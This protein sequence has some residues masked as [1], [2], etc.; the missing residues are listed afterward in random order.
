M[1]RS[2]ITWL[3]AALVAGVVISFVIPLCLL[4]RTMAEERAVSATN[5][6]AQSVAMIVAGVDDPASLPAVL[7]PTLGARTATTTVALPS[8]QLIGGPTTTGPVTTGQPSSG[9]AQFPEDAR[10]LAAVRADNRSMATTVDD[11]FHVL[12]PVGVADGVAIVHSVT[13]LGRV[14]RGVYGS[15][16]ILVA[17]GLLLVVVSVLV[18]RRQSA[19]ISTPVVAMA[20]VAHRL[21]SGDFEARAA[22]TGPVEVVELGHALNQLADRI[23][24]L[25]RIER[26]GA[27]D[28]SHRLRTPVTALRL[29]T[30]Q[31]EDPTVRAR[32]RSHVE[33]L[34]RAIDSVVA[35][36]R[37]PSRDAMG[38][39]C[40]ARVVLADRAHHWGPLAE[41]QGRMTTVIGGSA[42]GS[43][44]GAAGES[45]TGE[46]P[47]GEH[48]A[49]RPALVGLAARDL[50]DLLDNLVD[51]AFA[52]TPEETPIR[53]EL[54]VVDG[55][56]VLRVEDG[57][58]GSPDT[59]A[60]ARGESGAGSTGLGLDI[61]RR[62]A[63][64]AGGSVG[65]ERAGLGGLAVIV[66]LPLIE[67]AD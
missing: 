48:A 9:P 65:F 60:F 58:D 38:G 13:D 47:G 20:G 15:W 14:R 8:G 23:E 27:A 54:H 21:R 42:N 28:L 32:L 4:V 10:L 53:L 63:A 52:H 43:A 12:I 66:V 59:V 18:A 61:V 2:R 11:R 49:Y 44:S 3:A 30:D 33:D 50:A 31:V 46:H 25:L 6:D 40:D 36:A 56:V 7:A 51:N 41:D 35:D 1:L 17:V 57:G 22:A 67:R 64:D 5:S 39:W 29:D 26:E 16:A 19:R 34:H 45:V 24:D 37:R 55:L 62:L